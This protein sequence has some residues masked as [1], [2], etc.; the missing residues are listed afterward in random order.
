MTL[1]VAHVRRARGPAV[2]SSDR[3]KGRRLFSDPDAAG[4]PI[5]IRSRVASTENR[6]V[7]PNTSFRTLSDCVLAMF[8]EGTIWQ[9]QRTPKE[10]LKMRLFRESLPTWGTAL[11]RIHGVG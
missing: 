2:L 8:G 7:L 4:R 1:R 3:S 6:V 10:K 11:V 9:P 5:A